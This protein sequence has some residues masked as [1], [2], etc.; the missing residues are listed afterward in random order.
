MKKFLSKMLLILTLICISNTNVEYA[1]SD[2]IIPQNDIH[3]D[4]N[5]ND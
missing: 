2:F 1:D 4:H 5:A 3:I